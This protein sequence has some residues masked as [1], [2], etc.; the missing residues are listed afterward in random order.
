MYKRSLLFLSKQ[1]TAAKKKKNF[2]SWL[3]MR[4]FL[5]V[6]KNESLFYP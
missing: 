3:D 2:I 6:L 1:I 5:F 4:T